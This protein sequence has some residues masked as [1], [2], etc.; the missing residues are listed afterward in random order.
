MSNTE[1][2]TPKD[3]TCAVMGKPIDPP[4]LFV[5]ADRLH[6]T[7]SFAKKFHR[8]GDGAAIGFCLFNG[9]WCFYFVNEVGLKM[10]LQ[11]KIS[12]NPNGTGYSLDIRREADEDKQKDLIARLIQAAGAN[13]FPIKMVLS[14]R[15]YSEALNRGF[16]PLTVVA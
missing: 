3:E 10:D 16:Y 15:I 4:I 8:F 7:F 6:F 13:T 9:K 12:I 2:L 1:I 11:F 14:K 5:Y